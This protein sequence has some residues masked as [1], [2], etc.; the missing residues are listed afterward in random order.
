MK[1]P[2]GVTAV[3]Y[4]NED[5]VQWMYY[6]S[7]WASALKKLKETKKPCKKKKVAPRRKKQ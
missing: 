2:I 6:S 3:W 4:K 5:S 7:T 1:A